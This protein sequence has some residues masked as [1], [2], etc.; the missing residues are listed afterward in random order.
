MGCE[1]C[2]NLV[3]K[4]VFEVLSTI[5]HIWRKSIVKC[6]CK[7]FRQIMYERSSEC[8]S[9]NFRQIKCGRDNETIRLKV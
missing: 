3:A 4:V 9:K 7:D 1:L 5:I 8:N 2:G 6:N